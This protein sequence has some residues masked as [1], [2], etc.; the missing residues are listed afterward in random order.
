MEK[1]DDDMLCND[2][3][4]DGNIRSKCEENEGTDC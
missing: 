2:S 3:D 1:S 4:E